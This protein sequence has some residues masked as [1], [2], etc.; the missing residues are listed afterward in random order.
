MREIVLVIGIVLFGSIKSNAQTQWWNKLK[1]WVVM[2]DSS[3]THKLDD[4]MAE[5]NVHGVSIATI[6]SGKIETSNVFLNEKGELIVPKSGTNHKFQAGSISKTVAALGVL[7]L[8]DKN[9]EISLDDP[10]NNY[11]KRWFVADSLFDK[12]ITLRQLLSHT[13][14][15]NVHGFPGYKSIKKAA[16]L[17]EVL[18]GEGN[19]DEVM[20]IFPSDSTWKYSGGGYE[21]LQLMVE[22]VSGMPFWEYLEKE[23]LVPLQMT[24]STYKLLG[25]ED[26]PNCAFAYDEGVKKYKA[27]WYKYPESAA[28]GLWTTAMDL[29]TFFIHLGSIYSGQPGIISRKMFNEMIT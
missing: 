22:D 6:K 13:A 25:N 9:D 27:G 19:T 24:N 21:I 11:L 7:V 20:P 15:L 10:V 17:V 28:A 1:P 18:S 2:G 23:V 3:Y 16:T 5:F 4:A 12:P 29:S 14:G 26:C 8:V